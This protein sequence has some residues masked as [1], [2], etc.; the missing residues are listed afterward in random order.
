MSQDRPILLVDDDPLA[1][2]F[3]VR[4]LRRNG[5]HHPVVT[6]RD[7]REGLDYLAGTGLFAGTEPPLLPVL[8]LLDIKMPRMDG[9]EF[10]HAI[11]QM[12]ATR[13]VPVIMLTNSDEDRDVVRSYALGA[14]SYLRKPVDPY[15]L[16]KTARQLGLLDD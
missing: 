4:A 15:Q 10:L 12:P 14:N 9:V 8:I 6:A 13:D 7:G 16:A 11:R 1:A 2:E 3:V 5:L